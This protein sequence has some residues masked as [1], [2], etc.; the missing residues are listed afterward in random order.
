MAKIHGK[1]W[2]QFACYPLLTKKKTV[3]RSVGFHTLLQTT[4]GTDGANQAVTPFV[5]K[6]VAISLN[7]KLLQLKMRW[8]FVG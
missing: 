2:K 7:A 6:E 5:D 8:D 3:N 4:P 1:S